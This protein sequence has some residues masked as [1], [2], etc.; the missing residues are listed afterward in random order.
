[1]GKLG[2]PCRWHMRGRKWSD[3]SKG[4]VTCQNKAGNDETKTRRNLT[5]AWQSLICIVT[6]YYPSINRALLC[7][8][9]STGGRVWLTA[10][11]SCD[12]RQLS[13]S[14]LQQDQSV[15]VRTTHWQNGN[16][17]MKGLNTRTV[18]HS[19]RVEAPLKWGIFRPLADQ[20]YTLYRL[21][22]IFTLCKPAHSDDNVQE[23]AEPGLEH[24]WAWACREVPHTLILMTGNLTRPYRTSLFKALAEWDFS[25]QHCNSIKFEK[26]KRIILL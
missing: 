16:R 15:R 11:C 13:Q 3:T 26:K 4:L 17:T 21:H 14:W 2:W 9:V 24:V 8:W 6:N 5:T 22:F 10:C 19:L 7:T 23:R 12:R 20:L 18:N 1:M 25:L